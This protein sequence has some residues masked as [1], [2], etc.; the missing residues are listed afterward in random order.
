MIKYLLLTEFRV[1]TVS[2]RPISFFP[3]DLQPNCEAL[4]PK[5]N[6]NKRGSV[7]YSMDQENK[8]SKIFIVSVRLTGAGVQERKLSNLAG[9]TVKYS[10]QN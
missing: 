2:Y 1:C 10:L 9:C 6:M 5:N 8:V 4:R 7:T 3:I